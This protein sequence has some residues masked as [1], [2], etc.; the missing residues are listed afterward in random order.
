MQC[1]KLT[2]AVGYCERRDWRALAPAEGLM[3]RI[4]T[5]VFGFVFSGEERKWWVRPRPMPDAPP[6]MMMDFGRGIVVLGGDWRGGYF[7]V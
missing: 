4:V 7:P 2:L 1:S 5:W 6:V 3:S